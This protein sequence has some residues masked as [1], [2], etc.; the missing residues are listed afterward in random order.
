MH[1]M[2]AIG[3]K[4]DQRTYDCM[5]SLLTILHYRTLSCHSLI[6]SAFVTAHTAAAAGNN[7]SGNTNAVASS[8]SNPPAADGIWSR[9]GPIA[10][11]ADALPGRYYARHTKGN[12]FP[13]TMLINSYQSARAAQAARARAQKLLSSFDEEDTDSSYSDTSSND[14]TASSS[15]G[16]ASEDRDDTVADTEGAHEKR[17]RKRRKRSSTSTMTPSA[18]AS[19][20]A[21]T[22]GVPATASSPS[23]PITSALTGR[24][25]RIKVRLGR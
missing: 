5:H 10:S 20:V 24:Q 18:A 8:A 21:R 11:M 3:R 12:P 16:E 1:G 19:S 15:S 25:A 7:S 13:K 9:P 23:L 6:M 4:P 2:K 14:S 22:A 17:K